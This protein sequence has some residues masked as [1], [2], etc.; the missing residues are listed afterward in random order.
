[1]F[2][3]LARGIAHTHLMLVIISDSFSWL[4]ELVNTERFDDM[5]LKYGYVSNFER[6]AWTEQQ[7]RTFAFRWDGAL[8]CIRKLHENSGY[9][10]NSYFNCALAVPV[11]MTEKFPLGLRGIPD[12]LPGN[13][14]HI[15]QSVEAQKQKYISKTKG[16]AENGYRG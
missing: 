10:Q 8:S 12:L 15:F 9:K 11:M 13:I 2:L 5:K 4:A 3:K 6:L 14:S 1:M 7:E 16:H